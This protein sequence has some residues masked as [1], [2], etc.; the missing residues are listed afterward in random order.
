MSNKQNQCV[1][2]ISHGKIL[3]CELFEQYKD[4]RQILLDTHFSD[5]QY[6]MKLFS[7]ELCDRIIL[8]SL[9]TDDIKT[10]IG[11]KLG[12]FI[13]E[14]RAIAWDF[15]FV[16]RNPIVTTETIE[17]MSPH[18]NNNYVDKHSEFAIGI[19]NSIARNP[20]ITAEFLYRHPDI[21]WNWN[22]LSKNPKISAELAEIK[23]SNKS[24]SLLS[25]IVNSIFNTRPNTSDDI[26]NADR[27][28]ATMDLAEQQSPCFALKCLDKHPI[29]LWTLWTNPNKVAIKFGK[30][31]YEQLLIEIENY[32][33]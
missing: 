32:F 21:P 14:H 8:K 26:D 29:S 24:S 15:R 30:I 1:C 20:N 25:R 6:T 28:C 12:Q 9:T 5:N 16:F 33:V 7:T 22:I 4:V 23:R 2:G 18:L 31:E 13:T 17:R 10:F 19:W 27:I 3:L 11:N